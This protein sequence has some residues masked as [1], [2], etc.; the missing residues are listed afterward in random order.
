M[1]Y[2]EKRENRISIFEEMIGI[3]ER[4]Q[5]LVK[6]IHNSRERTLI[7][8]NP[9]PETLKPAEY[10]DAPCTI[11]TRNLSVLE[12]VQ[13]MYKGFPDGRIGLLNLVPAVK[14]REGIIRESIDQEQCL[15]SCTTLYPCLNMPPLLKE[16]SLNCEKGLSSCRDIYIYTPAVM[17]IKADKDEPGILG[18][19]HWVSFDVISCAIMDRER[20]SDIM[21]DSQRDMHMAGNDI[22]EYLE[23]KFCGILQLAAHNGAD[24][25]VLDVL[26]LNARYDSAHIV[27]E[28]LQKALK[29]FEYCFRAVILPAFSLTVS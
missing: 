6:A 5:R 26:R 20:K 22:E 10:W 19:E 24:I 23:N 27:E 2:E 11:A 28:A 17:Q 9:V 1:G 14:Y 13:E 3:C 16:Y 29:Q 21:S 7:Y 15:Y 25:L 4:E 18:Q 8:E 12:A